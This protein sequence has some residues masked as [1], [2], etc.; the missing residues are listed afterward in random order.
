MGLTKPVAAY[1]EQLRERLKLASDIA[2]DNC[3]STQKRYADN[4]NAGTQAKC[5]ARGM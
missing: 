3:K 5:S 2:L 4:L 1:L